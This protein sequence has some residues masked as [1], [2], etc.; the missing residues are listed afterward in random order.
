VLPLCHMTRWRWS[1]RHDAFMNRCNLRLDG[2]AQKHTRQV[3]QMIGDH[4]KL[5]CPQSWA[6]Y[7]E[8][9]I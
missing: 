8:G 7:V 9:D 3:A 5:A 4:V 2:H 6:S 1:G